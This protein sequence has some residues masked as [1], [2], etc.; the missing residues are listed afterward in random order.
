VFDRRQVP[1][2][3][4]NIDVATSVDSAGVVAALVRSLKQAGQ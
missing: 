2:W 4:P 1:E 3:R